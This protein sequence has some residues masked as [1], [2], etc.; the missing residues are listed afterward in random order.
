ME[1]LMFDTYEELS[2]KA[3]DDL[4]ELMKLRKDP[5]LCVASGDSPAGM[6]QNIADK[7]FKNE[8]DISNW[9][10]LGLDEWVGMNGR[11]EGSC[12]FHLNKDFFYPLKVDENRIFFFDGRVTDLNK[13]CEVAENFILQHGGIDTTILGLGLNGHIGMNEPNTSASSR[14]HVTELDPI[15]QQTGQKYFKKEQQL[16]N[17]ITLGLGTLMESENIL[18]IVSGS[19]KAAIVR[20]MLEAEISEDIPASLL[21]KHRGARIYL[22]AEAA[23]LLDSSK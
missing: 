12:R 22:D 1:V 7:V 9:S 11:D 19:K 18:L 3:A 8:L 10:F 20:K 4:I 15:T 16:K 2:K 13:E 17:G 5:L 6:Y 14:S 21:R 23:K